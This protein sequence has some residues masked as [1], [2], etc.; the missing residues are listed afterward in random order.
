MKTMTVSVQVPALRCNGPL[1]LVISLN[2]IGPNGELLAEDP[3]RKSYFRY[4]TDGERFLAQGYKDSCIAF[5]GKKQ[6]RKASGNAYAI[7]MM[8][9]NILPI[10]DAVALG[11]SKLAATSAVGAEKSDTPDMAG[12]GNSIVSVSPRK[13]LRTK[14]SAANISMKGSKLSTRNVQIASV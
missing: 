5:F 9:S 13:R 1:L 11:K 10:F 2:R 12:N 3:T 7:P 14:V 4:L 8:A 6:A